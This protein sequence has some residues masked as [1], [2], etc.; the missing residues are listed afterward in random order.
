M[1][2]TTI[3]FVTRI[4]M[5]VIHLPDVSNAIES[6]STKKCI[7]INIFYRLLQRYNKYSQLEIVW[8]VE[9]VQ[10]ISSTKGVAL[11]WTIE[12]PHIRLSIATKALGWVGFGIF[13]AG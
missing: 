7:A 8:K 13:E 3:G 11:H 1:L 9:S 5:S 12:E 6:L 10:D 2:L 4:M